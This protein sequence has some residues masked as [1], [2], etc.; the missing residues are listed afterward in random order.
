MSLS[1]AI[2]RMAGNI[3]CLGNQVSLERNVPG[4]ARTEG[5]VNG[6]GNRAVIDDTVITAGKPH[7]IHCLTGQIPQTQTHKPHHGITPPESAKGVVAQ[8]NTLARSGLSGNGQVLVFAAE[9]KLRFQTDEPGH[10]KHNSARPCGFNRRTQGARAGILEI[11]HMYH[12]S[13][14]SAKCETPISLRRGKGKMANTELPGI[15]ACNIALI[16]NRIDTPCVVP[17]RIVGCNG[18]CI[19]IIFY[20]GQFFRW[21][22]VYDR[23]LPDHCQKPYKHNVRRRISRVSNSMLSHHCH[24]RHDVHSF[25]GMGLRAFLAGSA[26]SSAKP[27]RITLS[28]W[29]AVI[30]MTTGS[31]VSGLKLNKG[32]C[33]LVI[34]VCFD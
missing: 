8:T 17:Q 22:Q 28:P 7:S 1:F 14:A 20:R 6:P 30:R 29:V 34:V 19:R 9:D 15:A 18:R 10:I 3:E 27:L 12:T 26:T 25:A 23:Q 24:H 11:S 21:Q 13:S 31:P 16:I 4:T 5:L 33:D 2:M 32:S